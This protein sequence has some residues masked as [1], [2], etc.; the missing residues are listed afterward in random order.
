VFFITLLFYAVAT[1]LLSA[2]ALTMIETNV[3]LGFLDYPAPYD[4]IVAACRALVYVGPAFFGATAVLS[5]LTARRSP[6]K[7]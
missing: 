6:E 2:I 5:L 4:W 3:G 7:D 1:F